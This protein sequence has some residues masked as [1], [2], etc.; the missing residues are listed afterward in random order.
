MLVPVVISA[1]VE[2]AVPRHVIHEGTDFIIVRQSWMELHSIST[3]QVDWLPPW[4]ESGI[5]E[6]A[7]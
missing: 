6:R 5:V 7:D 4:R 2:I 1:V 3:V